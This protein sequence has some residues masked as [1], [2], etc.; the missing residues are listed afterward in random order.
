MDRRAR[1]R[2]R[3]PKQLMAGWRRHHRVFHDRSDGPTE[4]H[5]G[6]MAVSN[7][8]AVS[9]Q[10]SSLP[11][12]WPPSRGPSAMGYGRRSR[13][14]ATPELTPAPTPIKPARSA[15][16]LET[17]T[18]TDHRSS[19]PSRCGGP[20]RAGAPHQGRTG[21][22]RRLAALSGELPGRPAHQRP[23][24]AHRPEPPSSPWVTTGVVIKGR[25][26]TR[27]LTTSWCIS[28]TVLVVGR[29]RSRDSG[30]LAGAGRRGP[31]PRPRSRTSPTFR[32]N[33]RD[34]GYLSG[35]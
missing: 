20:T 1:G 30:P 13:R 15:T 22:A 18:P 26:A 19:A 3:R 16:L 11:A 4:T 5:G 6:V 28:T 21:R 12:V 29:L 34:L 23:D 32:A 14:R 27:D 24:L 31:V 9:C 25:E 8:P 7:Y 10:T 33:L 35:R 2:T 17:S